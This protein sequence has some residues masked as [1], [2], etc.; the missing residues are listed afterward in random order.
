[1]IAKCLAVVDGRLI[2]VVNLRS[3]GVAV[4]AKQRESGE[5]E[6][7]RCDSISS[8]DAERALNID[9]GAGRTN[10]SIVPK[11]AEADLGDETRTPDF[12][13]ARARFI[14]R[15]RS[16]AHGVLKRAPWV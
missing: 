16:A 10:L 12:R 9:P 13:Q 5:V 4:G 11:I 15:G 8:S 1:M 14:T 6:L 3:L 2:I 7:G